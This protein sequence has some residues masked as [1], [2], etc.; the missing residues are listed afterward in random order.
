MKGSG[1]VEMQTDKLGGC[2]SLWFYAG[3]YGND[4]GA[5]LQVNYSMDGGQTWTEV[6]DLQSFD[7]WQRYG[8]AIEQPGSIR[9]QFKGG[10]VA[11]KRL[12]IDDI[13]MSHYDEETSISRPTTKGLTPALSEGEGVI[14]DLAGRRFNSQSSI[15]NSQLKKGIYIKNGKKVFIR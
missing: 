14:Y 7:G 12:N 13:Q 15:L 4:T 11:S 9:L 1:V 5:T 10:G 6:A 3:N 2:D 8:F